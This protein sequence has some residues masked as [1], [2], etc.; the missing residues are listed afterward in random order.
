MDDDRRDPSAPL[1]V[2]EI[3]AN[4]DKTI[5]VSLNKNRN[6][7]RICYCELVNVCSDWEN[8]AMNFELEP[9]QA[10][11]RPAALSN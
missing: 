2:Y 10:V 3:Y 5:W 1:P 6:R 11:P 8:A 7:F 9:I 4:A